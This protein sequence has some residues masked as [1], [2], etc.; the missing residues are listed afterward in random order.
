M[1]IYG[2]TCKR[3]IKIGQA[4]S[5]RRRLLSLQTANPFLLEIAIQVQA[6]P[7]LERSLHL[8]L[9]HLQVRGEWF[10]DCKELRDAFVNEPYAEEP[11]P[12]APQYRE[13]K[14]RKVFNPRRGA[15]IRDCREAAGIS[16]TLLAER[17]GQDV[18][19]LSRYE[20]DKRPMSEQLYYQLRTAI[21]AITEERKNAIKELEHGS[22]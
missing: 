9:Q 8:N 20:T 15:D 13:D 5:P 7:G 19:N 18:A 6:R 12:I 14:R 16:L 21:Y 3:F 10:R 22:T 17:T 2:I 1:Y 11:T 4:A